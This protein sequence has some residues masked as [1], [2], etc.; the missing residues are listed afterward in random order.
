[1]NMITRGNKSISLQLDI[2]GTIDQWKVL[3]RQFEPSLIG[4][5]T[6]LAGKR[7][8]RL[9]RE[10]V[11]DVENILISYFENGDAVLLRIMRLPCDA[12]KV[13]P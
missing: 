13:T 2:P 8:V 7:G 6:L 9:G 3:L 5:E 1:M 12:Q 4:L 11:D 10:T